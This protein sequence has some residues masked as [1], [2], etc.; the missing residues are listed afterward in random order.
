MRC[1]KNNR[2]AA[3]VEWGYGDVVRKSGREGKKVEEREE[4]FGK[5]RR[6]FESRWATG[7]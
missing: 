4:E 5:S 6:G 2:R 7:R 3:G 1:T